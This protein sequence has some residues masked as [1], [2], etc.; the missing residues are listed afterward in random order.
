MDIAPGDDELNA[1][2]ERLSSASSLPGRHAGFRALTAT[3]TAT[4]I[5]TWITTWIEIRTRATVQPDLLRQA[6]SVPAIAGS[7]APVRSIRPELIRAAMGGT[8]DTLL[9]FA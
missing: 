4:W 9:V 5:T 6:C 1:P 2:L 3:W 7:A 8:A